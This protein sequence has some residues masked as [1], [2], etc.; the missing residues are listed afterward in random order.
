MVKISEINDPDKVRPGKKVSSRG[1]GDL[2]Q[3]VQ[4]GFNQA[5][6]AH[7][8]LNIEFDVKKLA[9]V[10]QHREYGTRFKSGWK[11]KYGL[12][13]AQVIASSA[14]RLLVLRKEQK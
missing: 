7:S 5:I 3:G 14:G 13:R 2:A 1:D 8:A 9:E 11:Y 6:D 4:I 10:I 12:I